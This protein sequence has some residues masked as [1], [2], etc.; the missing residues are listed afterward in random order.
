M[1]AEEKEIRD[2]ERKVFAE[3]RKWRRLVQKEEEAMTPEEYEEHRKKLRKEIRAM[4]I[5]LVSSLK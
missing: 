1:T 2:S 4:G 5:K 3:V